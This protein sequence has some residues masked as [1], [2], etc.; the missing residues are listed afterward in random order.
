MA[1]STLPHNLTVLTGMLPSESPQR[2]A[3]LSRRPKLT[4]LPTGPAAGLSTEVVD[5]IFEAFVTR[6]P[7]RRGKI[8]TLSRPIRKRYRYPW[9]VEIYGSGNIFPVSTPSRGKLVVLRDRLE[10]FLQD[11]SSFG[12]VFL[13]DTTFGEIENI[14]V[15]LPF[16][17]AIVSPL[18]AAAKDLKRLK[19]LKF[20]SWVDMV[21]LEGFMRDVGRVGSGFAGAAS[22]T[23][24]FG[25]WD[26]VPV[27]AF[28][29][30]VKCGL[31][32]L[33]SQ[34]LTTFGTAHPFF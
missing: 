32:I 26:V 22:L 17:D 1:P 15:R 23:L 24:V 34:S 33:R 10:R 8:T 21:D 25:A 18:R 2:G 7:A 14:S 30:V 19:Q 13:D 27:S 4:P 31:I 11:L 16:D 28:V 29:Y 9:S 20:S 12:S 5:L 6:F 3:F